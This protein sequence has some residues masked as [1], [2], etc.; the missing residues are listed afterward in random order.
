MRR[1]LIQWLHGFVP[2]PLAAGRFDAVHSVIGAGFGL[3]V[4]ALTTRV[5][6]PSLAAWLVAP[7]CASSV[8]LFCAPSSPIAQPWSVLGGNTVS[9]LVGVACF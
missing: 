6:D 8:L 4:A 1:T 5:L 9:S 3:L 2:Q 7:I